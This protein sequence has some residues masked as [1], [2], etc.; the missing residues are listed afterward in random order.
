MG[1]LETLKIN[2]HWVAIGWDRDGGFPMYVITTDTG[3]RAT[4]PA[5]PADECAKTGRTPCPIPTIGLDRG[6][7]PVDGKTGVDA[8]LWHCRTHCHGWH[9]VSART[10]AQRILDTYSPGK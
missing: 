1:T 2:D 4:F 9:E 7:H 5:C 3:Y 10:M 6:Q 8:W